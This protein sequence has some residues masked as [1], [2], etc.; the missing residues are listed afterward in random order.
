MKAGVH[1][2]RQ[3][4]RRNTEAQK[5]FILSDAVSVMG[6]VLSACHFFA[7][8]SG[9]SVC[10]ECVLQ[11]GRNM[12]N[13]IHN[14][15]EKT[16]L[17]ELLAILHLGEKPG[18]TPTPKKLRET[19]GAP[20]AEEERCLVYRNGWAVYE[21]ETG[22]TV[23]WL[24]DCVSFTYRF[25]KPKKDEARE[26]SACEEL[27]E[28]LLESQ[29]WPIAVTLA[30]DHRIEGNLMNRTGSRKGTKAYE[31]E[32]VPEYEEDT[33]EEAFIKEMFYHD[34]SVCENPETGFIRK[35]M[36]QEMLNR[37]TEKQRKAF[38][39]V[40]RYGYSEVEAASLMHISQQSVYR[41]LTRAR[42]TAKKFLKFDWRGV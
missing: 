11:K 18:K 13:R 10:R 41:L 19:G 34:A 20:V 32:L 38:V 22:R 42:V 7:A 26:G 2:G 36:I 40:Y 39:L 12:E 27:P 29:P 3:M 24:P 25:E 15:T 1:T 6:T 31:Y 9:A 8:V 23:F 33:P 21:N 28:G 17:G 37:M 30:G 5:K 4:F 35:E 14:I 16:T